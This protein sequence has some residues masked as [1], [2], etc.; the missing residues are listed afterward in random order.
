MDTQNEVAAK[1]I[2]RAI[3]E[4]LR[5]AREAEGWS[6]AEFITRLP[7][8][9]GERTLLAYEH[10]IRVLTVLRLLELCG[11]LGVV[12][13]V[14]LTMAL[15]RARIFLTNLNLYVD[16]RALLRDESRKFRPLAQWAKNRLNRCPDGIAE[17]APTS[18]GELADFIGCTHEE[19]A[20]YLAKFIPDTLPANRTAER[21]GLR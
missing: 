7:S 14:L 10:G 3:G 1:A 12:A 6:R 5:R 18:V 13:T 2:S 4:E 19:L 16:L 9:I 8:G 20:C 15:Q 11:A 21:V 17:L